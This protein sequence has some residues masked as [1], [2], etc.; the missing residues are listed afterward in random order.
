MAS[1]AER[2][3]S[4]AAKYQQEERAPAPTGGRLGDRLNAIAS[5]YSQEAAQ[6][7]PRGSFIDPLL[8]GVSFGAADEIGGWLFGPETRDKMR[9]DYA[10]YR[11]RRPWASMGGELLGALPTALVPGGAAMRGATLAGRIGRGMGIGAGTGALYG[12]NQGEGMLSADRLMRGVSGGATGGAIGGAL[13]AVGAGAGRLVR[14]MMDRFRPNAATKA[15]INRGAQSEINRTLAA[16]D[17]TMQDAAQRLREYGPD[18][19]LVDTSPGLRETGRQMVQFGSPGNAPL[20]ALGRQRGPQVAER[21][22]QAFSQVLGNRPKP[23][24]LVDALQE[25]ARRHADK[26]FGEAKDAVADPENVPFNPALKPVLDEQRAIMK[27]QRAPVGDLPDSNFDFLSEAQ[28]GISADKRAAQDALQRGGGSSAR[29]EADV[30]KADEAEILIALDNVTDGKFSIARSK[31]ADDKRLQEAF[32]YGFKDAMSS[33]TEISFLEKRW[34]GMTKEEKV[35]A[36][37]GVRAWLGQK[38]ASFRGA[39]TQG[40]NVWREGDHKSKLKVI[41]GEDTTERLAKAMEGQEAMWVTDDALVRSGGSQTARNV[42]GRLN[43]ENQ[44]LPMDMSILGTA[45]RGG[46]RALNAFNRPDA[47]TRSL[48][49]TLAAQGADAQRLVQALIDS[50]QGYNGSRAIQSILQ[51]AGGGAVMAPATT[52][53]PEDILQLVVRP[54]R[55]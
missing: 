8:Q 6:P 53:Q 48:G 46:Q 34:A 43:P 37:A 4:I 45:V 14:A 25:R 19:A 39:R 33:G 3:D 24:K 10:A 23:A 42:T 52:M 30:A 13:P 1:L 18:A 5:K 50:Q 7:E 32:D 11:E 22:D 12:A 26:L 44:R 21:V 20:A 38:S 17:M 35:A 9:E 15:G 54:K 28:K 51:N 2:L 27:R 41:Y 16:D 47:M 49:P 36:R 31:Y 55:R 29:R 40:R